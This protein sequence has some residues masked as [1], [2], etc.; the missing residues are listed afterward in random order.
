M[1]PVDSLSRN[2]APE[3]TI[4][5]PL[6][7]RN[8]ANP[9]WVDNTYTIGEILK[10]QESDEDLQR[11]TKEWKQ[12]TRR[13]WHRVVKDEVIYYTKKGSKRL[14]LAIPFNIE[15][16]ILDFHHLPAHYG[17]NRMYNKLKQ[18]YIFPKM[19]SKI[20]T[21]IAECEMCVA[22][23][24]RKRVKTNPIPFTT[25]MHP[26]MIVQADLMGPLTK[27]LHGNQ[28]IL[29]VI[30]GLTRYCE[31][32]A[33]PSKTAESVGIGLMDIF[34][35]RG[36][37]L[38]LHTDNGSDFKSHDMQNM[39][40][41]V[42]VRLMH[43]APFRPQSQ[44][45]VERLNREIGKSLQVLQSEDVN[46][47]Q[48]IPAIQLSLNLSYN[49]VLGM[50]PFQAIHGWLLCR[51]A[52]IP[53]TFDYEKSLDS[54]EGKQ[55]CRDLVIRMHYSIADQ[56]VKQENS[57]RAEPLAH[58][59]KELPIGTRCLIYHP[60]PRNVMGK[61]YQNWKGVFIVKKRI[62]VYTYVMTAELQPRKEFI[63][64]IER[65]RPL[66]IVSNK[67]V[68]EKETETI[69]KGPE[70]TIVVNEDEADKPLTPAVRS[71]GRTAK[72]NY[73]KFYYVMFKIKFLLI[74]RKY[75]LI[76]FMIQVIQKLSLV[77]NLI[78]INYMKKDLLKKNFFSN[79][80]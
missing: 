2:F 78:L 66:G 24:V 52:F 50:S 25:S 75:F 51:P 10:A 59:V 32:R 70:K 68:T 40:K 26:F 31:L 74:C 8:K 47:D 57:K 71:S 27:T 45:Q 60:Q 1:L 76:C 42:G 21:Y 5:K 64:H 14:R 12:F 29:A 44:G 80:F 72:K 13:N 7:I 9:F 15:N 35:V 19:H 61:T 41:A 43:G 73:K 67:K 23:K 4:I 63:C 28:Y 34:M 33:I 3:V 37:P 11:G 46:W 16:K 6:P 56:Y 55:W 36:P 48:D 65:I 58:E 38:S 62:D 54:F 22:F 69:E 53:P 30:C 20:K 18:N 17:T 79:F 77:K 49:R 39:M